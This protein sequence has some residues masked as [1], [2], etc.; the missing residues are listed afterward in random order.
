MSTNAAIYM[1]EMVAFV[2]L[3]IIATISH[4]KTQR[5]ALAGSSPKLLDIGQWHTPY[6][7][8]ETDRNMNAH[9]TCMVSAA[10]CARVSYLTHDN[11]RDTRQ[12][13]RG[14]PAARFPA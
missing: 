11:Q 9:E 3:V 8:P 7:D 5:A 1:F 12:T 14:Q 4:R 6:V 10:R 2:A 13:G